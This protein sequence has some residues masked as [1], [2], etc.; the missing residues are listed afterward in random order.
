M[1]LEY[2]RSCNWE[3]VNYLEEFITE[4]LWEYL[5]TNVD[6]IPKM[7]RIKVTVEFEGI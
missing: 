4:P 6:E 2:T 1:K 5:Q 7:S 3:S